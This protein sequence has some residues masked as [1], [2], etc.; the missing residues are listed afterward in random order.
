MIPQKLEFPH[1]GFIR[2]G[3][4]NFYGKRRASR[5]FHLRSNPGAYPVLDAQGLAAKLGVRSQLKVAYADHG[6]YSDWAVRTIRFF[7]QHL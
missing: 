2:W 7:E 5:T 1:F 3:G 4:C 6:F